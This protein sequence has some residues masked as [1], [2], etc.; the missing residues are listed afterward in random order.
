MSKVVINIQASIR[1]K[2]KNISANSGKD[3]NKILRQY[4]QE[5]FLYRLSK[6]SY[7]ENFILKG[8]FLFL[9]YGISRTRPTRDI[10]F[11]GT[12]ISNSAKDIK[13]IMKTVV[14]LNYEDG[15][16]FDNKNIEVNDIIQDGE[17][18]GVRVKINTKLGSVK[19]RIQ[20]DIGFGDKITAGP[21]EIEF[22]TLLDLPA[23]KLKVYSLETAISE[24][25]ETIVSLQLQTSRMK[26]FYDIW[27]MMRQFEFKG[28]SLVEAIK[29][30]FKH[31]KTD[32]P[33]NKPLF[34]DEIYDEKS[35]RQTLWSAFLKKGD[36]QHA[37]DTLSVTA[38]EIEKDRKSVV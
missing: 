18:H 27:L 31:R 16:I 13:N 26:D 1:E 4:V 34:A 29:K 11:L 20:I 24:K 35:D 5:R 22:P 2:L 28:P 9:A 7:S 17:Y 19:E 15:L 30:T 23:P 36:I 10:D 6:S 14:S 12:S 32:I 21:I 3:F 38:K 37:P 25:F 33:K 8:A